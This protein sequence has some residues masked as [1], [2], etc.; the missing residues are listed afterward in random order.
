MGSSVSKESILA[1]ASS[2]YCCATTS[3]S[4][5]SCTIASLTCP[6]RCCSP[7]LTQL[8]SLR[9]G[10]NGLMVSCLTINAFLPIWGISLTVILFPTTILLCYGEVP[11]D[12]VLISRR[13]SN[14]A[15]FPSAKFPLEPSVT[16]RS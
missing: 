6:Y 7:P 13:S 5:N 1:R 12:V 14:F 3:C 16:F 15:N 8:C 2:T 11:C 10:P 4:M 9:R